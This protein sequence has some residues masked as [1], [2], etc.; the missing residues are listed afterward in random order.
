MI[1]CGGTDIYLVDLNISGAIIDS[2]HVDR[3]LM[4][5]ESHFPSRSEQQVKLCM[6]LT[7]PQIN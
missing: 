6:K 2:E 4:N 5:S 3:L 1:K 7:K